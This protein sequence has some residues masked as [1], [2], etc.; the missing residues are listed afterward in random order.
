M[1][2]V[3]FASIVG[4]M[5]EWEMVRP[6]IAHLRS[7]GVELIVVHDHGSS[8]RTMEV[9]A[10][11]EAAGD[12]WVVHIPVEATREV[13]TGILV[14]VA[15]SLDAEWILFHDTDELFVP[16]AGTLAGIS[17]LDDLDIVM[18]RRY[19]TVT[20]ADGPRMPVPLT[21][22][23]TDRLDLYA[24][25]VPDAYLLIPDN[26]DIPWIRGDLEPKVIARPWTVASVVDGQHGVVPPAWAAPRTAFADDVLIAHLPFTNVERFARKVANVRRAV[27]LEPDWFVDN[28]G[29]Q[30]SM[31]SHMEPEDAA[32][33][34]H[35]QEV[36][37]AELARLRE[38]GVVA[39][40]RAL[41][42][43]VIPS[44]E[45]EAGYIAALSSLDTWRRA[46]HEVCSRHRIRPEGPPELLS[47]GWFPVIG[48][49]PDRILKLYGPWRQGDLSAPLELAAYEA[50]AQ[51]RTLPVPVAEASGELGDGWRYLVLDRLPGD[52][53]GRAWAHLSGEARSG[54]AAWLGGFVRRLHALPLPEPM[55]AD[56]AAGFRGK[57]AWHRDHVVETLRA[58]GSLPARLIDEVPGWLPSSD[59]LIGDPRWVLVHGDLTTDHLLGELTPDGFAVSGVIDFGWAMVG[60][61]CY[62]IGPIWNRICRGDAARFRRCAVAGGLPEPMDLPGARTLLAW[63]LL[64]STD[65]FSMARDIAHAAADLDDLAE[66]MFLADLEPITPARSGGWGT[67]RRRV[68][69]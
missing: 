28:R 64:T 24:L 31:W 57:L 13:A 39:S 5:D 58:H 37:A 18:V 11:E 3:R 59:D 33:E 56:G 35:R 49:P 20:D 42:S 61:P 60:H 50:L 16:R 25:P 12:V 2:H 51:D 6:A 1:R 4:T 34:F 52:R 30:W 55:R 22:D 66:R 47:D 69:G 36:D 21:P 8:D 14:S 38:R 65:S 27:E 45:G 62:E 32:A 48:L 17:G 67:R 44:F 15:R 23:A 46:I 9:L 54:V 43:P 29:W 53:L 26:P 19:N 68:G 10:E 7:I 41:L 40:A 63:A